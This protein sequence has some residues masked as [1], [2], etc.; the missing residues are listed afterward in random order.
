MLSRRDVPAPAASLAAEAGMTIFERAFEAR[1]GDGRRGTSGFMPGRR[2]QSSRVLSRGCGNGGPKGHG[3]VRD[4][5][6]NL[7]RRQRI[8]NPDGDLRDPRPNDI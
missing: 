2:T 4:G 8:K 3:G 1:V 6:P 5:S 7:Q